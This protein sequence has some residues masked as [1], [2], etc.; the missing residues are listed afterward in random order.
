MEPVTKDNNIIIECPHCKKDNIII[1][2]HTNCQKCDKSF[3]GMKF[4]KAAVSIIMTGFLISSG[5]LG[6]KQYQIN[7]HRYP[8]SAEFFLI[9]SCL[10]A[11]GNVVSRETADQKLSLCVNLL[12]KVQKQI[13]YS[14]FQNNKS[15]FF[16]EFKKQ[17]FMQH[18]YNQ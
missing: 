1:L 3:S 6:Y 2:D 8:A 12:E 11:S 5:F 4:Q 18:Q 9:D 14:E 16:D 17:I 10:S 15:K 13:S 7:S